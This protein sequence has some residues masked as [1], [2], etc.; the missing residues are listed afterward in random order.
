M[1]LIITP[2]LEGLKREWREAADILG[3]TRLSTGGWWRCRS[4]SRRSSA[5]MAL[6]FA[7]AFG[8][9]ATAIALTGPSLNIAPILL[10]AQI[11]GDVLGN[12]NLGY[13]LAFGMISDHR[14]GQ[15][16]LYRAAPAGREVA[17][18]TRFAAWAAIIFRV[19]VFPDADDRNDGVLAV[20]AARRLF[21]GCLPRRHGRPA[22]SGDICLF[23]DHGVADDRLRR[24]AGC[25]DRLLGAAQDAAYAAGGRVR[26]PA[27]TRDSR[28]RRGFRLHQALQY[29][30][31]GYR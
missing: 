8:A 18:M 28:H 6:L 27:A 19:P 10:Y 2:A 5:R 30:G 14:G 12:P 21:A 11:R 26:H 9:V 22:I 17:E 23:V 24:A 13:A 16:A 20:H 29:V 25:A 7:N 1:I 15:H 3:A 4:C 31:F